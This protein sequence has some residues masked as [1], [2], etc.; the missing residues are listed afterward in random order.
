MKRTFN[1]DLQGG[2]TGKVIVEATTN[3]VKYTHHR[4]GTVVVS[5]DRARGQL[6]RQAPT[7]AVARALKDAADY[8]DSNG[9]G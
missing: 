7:N 3:G 8:C 5:P 2:G 9:W 4:S 6:V 1:V